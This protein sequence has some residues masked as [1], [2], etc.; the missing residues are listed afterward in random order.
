MNRPYAKLTITKKGER[1]ARSGHPWVYGEEVTHVEGTY[2]T[3]D[4]VDVYSDKDRYLGTGFANDISKIRVR[5]VS[6]NANDRFDEAFWQRRV[7]YALDYRKTVMGDKDFA[8]CRLIF[9]DADDMPGLTVDRYNDVLVAQTLCYGMDQVKPV[10]FK[11]LV[12][13]LAAMGVTIRGI[14]ERNDVK[15]RKLDGMEEYKG[16]YEAD[17]LPQPGS[18]LTTIDENGILYDVDVENG[19]KTGFFLDQKYNRLAVAKIAAGKHVLDCFTHTGAFALNAAKGGAA[20]VTA[21]DISQEAVD[22]T[23]ENIRRNGLEAIVTAKQANV[24]DLLTDLADHKC[25]DYDFIILDPPAF[26]K[27]GH[28]VRNAIRGYKEINLKAMKLLP[29]GGYLATCSCSHFMRDDLFRQMLHDAAKDA[30]V[31]LR[32]IEGRQQSPDHPIL[33]NVPE[34]N[35]LKFYLFQVV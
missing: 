3:G 25:H 18:V 6:R 27:S 32:Q 15:V 8:C 14:Y 29:R 12:D 23:N 35:Y 5:I 20:S 31:R 33:W 24:F 17:F 11:A 30:G 22:M 2:Q 10:I 16:W 34:T 21:V 13:E 4:I 9:G 19:Q 26:T 7:K 1:A 28:T